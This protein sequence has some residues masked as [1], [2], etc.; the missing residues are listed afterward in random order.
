VTIDG[1]QD[2]FDSGITVQNMTGLN[3]AGS[4]NILFVLNVCSTGAVNSASDNSGITAPWQRL[5]F[6][7]GSN[8][9]LWWTKATGVFTG[10]TITLNLSTA[11]NSWN[12]LW[13]VNGANFSSPFDPN[14]AL[15][16]IGTSSPV[17]ITTSNPNDMLFAC[18]GTDFSTDEIPGAGWTE[19]FDLQNM[20]VE[21]QLV[22][23]KQTALS[24]AFTNTGTTYGGI[25]F[26]V[27]ANQSF[28]GAANFVGAGD[29]DI[30]ATVSSIGLFVSTIVLDNGLLRLDTNTDKIYVCSQ[31]PASYTEATSTYALGNKNLGVGNVFGAPAAASPN[32]RKVTSVSV[33]D[34]SITGTGTVSAWAVVDSVNSALLASGNLSG[35]KAVTSGQVWTL[36]PIIIHLPNQ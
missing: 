17:S 11:A 22:S 31:Q 24:A 19:L 13:G 34:G 28:A 18:Y 16:V 21:R 2:W 27:T 10:A 9:S 14:G 36:D 33:T 7:P 6:A 29:F 35:A 25:G 12:F 4:N 20:F 23:A 3:C 26:A 5:A 30:V 1:Q 8:M 15:P 32:G